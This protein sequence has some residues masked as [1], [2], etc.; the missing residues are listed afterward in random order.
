[1]DKI[2]L[3]ADLHKFRITFATTLTTLAGYALAS[4]TV[5]KRVILVL[6]GIFILASGSAAFNHF[7]ERNTDILMKRTRNR[8]IPSG[9]IKPS[10]VVVI[11]LLEI[12]GGTI[13]IYTGSGFVAAF[14][15]FLA[16]VWYNLVYT[17]LKKITSFAVIPGSVIGAIPPMVG[18]VAGGGSLL[19]PALFVLA[20]FFFMSQVP[21]FWLLMLHY[22]DDY[23]AAGFPVINNVLTYTQIKRV[24]FVWIVATALNIVL[25][26]FAGLFETFVFKAVVL[27]AAVQLI[28]VF[29][30]LL[31]KSNENFDPFR[32]FS[33]LN[34]IMLVIILSMI[35][36]PLF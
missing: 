7:Q 24:T 1:M 2:R 14:L 11:A 21:H 26:V 36:D 23:N 34:Y 32:Y 27:S 22:G 6:I 12:I 16:F 13:L 3:I 4:G 31:R 30:G 33:Q 5:D 10:A 15:G 8:P 17:P 18:W 25:L 35:L 20:F 19:D 28:V 9:K 29:S